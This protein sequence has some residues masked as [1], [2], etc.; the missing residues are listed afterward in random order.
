MLANI[1]E[2]DESIYSLDEDYSPHTPEII[3]HA[4][5]QLSIEQFNAMSNGEDTPAP[6]ADSQ[7]SLPIFE[8]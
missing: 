6:V 2:I 1:E 8:P 7:P 3:E 4:Y 5:N